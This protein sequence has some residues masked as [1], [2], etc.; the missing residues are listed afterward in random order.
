MSTGLS[1]YYKLFGLP[2]TASQENIKRR[3]R[4]LAMRYHPDKQGGDKRKFIEIK[5]AYEYLSGQR[6]IGQSQ[7]TYTYSPSRSTSQARQQSQEERIKQAQQRKRENEYKEYIENERYFRHLTSGKRWN[8]IKLAAYI[9]VFLSF[10]LTIDLFLP[11][12]YEQERIIA[13][14]NYTIGGLDANVY[15]VRRLYTESGR[16]YFSEEFSIIY[17]SDPDV[18]LVKSALFHNEIGFIPFYNRAEMFTD[19]KNDNIFRIQFTLGAHATLLIPFF[20][21]PFLIIV[22]KRKTFSFTVFY[23]ISLYISVP[24]IFYYLFSND[25]WLHLLTLGMV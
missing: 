4:Q 18:L 23:F 11:Y 20:M 7:Q 15:S 21:L 12:R 10:L 2:E 16:S 8:F 19:H 14:D 3:Y 6:T 24:L 5:E 13:Y 17:F 1:K 22:F 25:R 9:G